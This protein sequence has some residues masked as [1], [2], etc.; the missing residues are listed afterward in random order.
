M[1]VVNEEERR[2]HW[3]DG[4]LAFF[5]QLPCTYVLRTVASVIYVF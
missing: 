3:K 1:G 5:P 4:F 2:S